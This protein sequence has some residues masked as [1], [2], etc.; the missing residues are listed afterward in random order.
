[1]KKTACTVKL[2]KALGNVLTLDVAGAERCRNNMDTDGLIR[3]VSKIRD[4][5]MTEM[6]R[7]QEIKEE[8]R[9]EDDFAKFS[10]RTDPSYASYQPKDLGWG[11][12]PEL[13]RKEIMDNYRREVKDLETVDI[14]THDKVMSKIFEDFKRKYNINKIIV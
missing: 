4:I 5:L 12:I 7:L 1:M 9:L 3:H 10:R 6:N 8:C 14:K 11:E 2:I 13:A